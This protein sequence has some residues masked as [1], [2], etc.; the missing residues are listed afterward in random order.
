MQSAIQALLASEL[1][2]YHTDRMLG[3]VMSEAQEVSMCKA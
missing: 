2:K 1:F 3:I